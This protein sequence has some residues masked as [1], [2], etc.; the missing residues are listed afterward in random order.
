M[1][2]DQLFEKGEPAA[3]PAGE[4]AKAPAGEQQVGVTQADIDKSIGALKE[5]IGGA[6]QGLKQSLDALKPTKEPD[7]EPTLTDKQQ[8]LLQDP[9]QYIQSVT[10]KNRDQE[11]DSERQVLLQGSQTAIVRNQK[12]AFEKEFGEEVWE[13]EMQKDLDLVLG[14]MT[15]AMRASEA[16]VMAA[17]NGLIG[18]KRKVLFEKSA[19]VSKKKQEVPTMMTGVGRPRPSGP[20]LSPDEKASLERWEDKG[21]D[22]PGGAKQYLIDREA[23]ETEDD[24]PAAVEEK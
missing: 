24:F 19:E 20:A 4:P 16:H 14:S 10:G 5:D 17:I 23:G 2:D 7:P 3:A 12:E 13:A 21:A 9:D 22:Y 1:A 6:M 18:Q 11:L 8:A 15:P